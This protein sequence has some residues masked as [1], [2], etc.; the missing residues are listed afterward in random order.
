MGLCRYLV[1]EW[2]GCCGGRGGG[3]VVLLWPSFVLSCLL[4]VE[5]DVGLSSAD[6]LRRTHIQLRVITVNP[7]ASF[8]VVAVGSVVAR[9]KALPMM[10]HH[11]R[12][13]VEEVLWTW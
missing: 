3:I 1:A 7:E 5:K 9:A 4:C 8:C 11:S 6:L 12:E 10:H 2:S 13:F